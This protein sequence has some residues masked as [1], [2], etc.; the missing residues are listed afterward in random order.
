MLQQ[1]HLLN[2]AFLLPSPSHRRPVSCCRASKI[3][4]LREWMMVWSFIRLSSRR[5]YHYA[6][7]TS[8]KMRWCLFPFSSGLHQLIP[9]HH[10]PSLEICLS[11]S[12]SKWEY[13]FCQIHIVC[14]RHPQ[15][16]DHPNSDQ[17]PK[18]PKWQGPWPQQKSFACQDSGSG[19]LPGP[20]FRWVTSSKMINHIYHI[21]ESQDSTLVIIL[22][23]H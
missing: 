18:W 15:S 17:W 19:Y 22:L 8:C 10:R 6:I 14:R 20:T 21:N 3:D 16:S 7:L 23:A 1:R 12:N 11:C 9:E 13:S 2:W 5:L 4:D